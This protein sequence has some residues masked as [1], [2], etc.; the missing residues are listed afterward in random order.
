MKNVHHKNI[1]NLVEIYEGKTNL[2]LVY[3]NISGI[4]LNFLPI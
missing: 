4:S 3:E 1:I 2:Y